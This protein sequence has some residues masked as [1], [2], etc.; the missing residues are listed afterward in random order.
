MCLSSDCH[1]LIRSSLPI[2]ARQ[3]PHHVDLPSSLL[4]LP[5]TFFLA[6]SSL[7]MIPSLFLVFSFR[8]LDYWFNFIV[9]LSHLHGLILYKENIKLNCL[10]K[11]F[12]SFSGSKYFFR[13]NI[14]LEI[15]NKRKYCFILRKTFNK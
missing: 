12:D 2:I 1:V 7:N 13:P 6:F 11:P 3:S 8:T 14:V 15:Q 5:T 4:F 10:V 9:H